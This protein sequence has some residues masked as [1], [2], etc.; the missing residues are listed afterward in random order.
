VSEIVRVQ[1]RAVQVGDRV[2]FDGGFEYLVVHRDGDAVTIERPD[3]PLS[4]KTGRPDPRSWADILAPTHAEAV[5]TVKDVLGASTLA[6]EVEGQVTRCPPLSQLVGD[7]ERLTEHLR[8][9]HDG[10]LLTKHVSL[11]DAGVMA[12]PHR[13]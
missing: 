13:H 11:H 8:A 7:A 12:I 2:R 1:W 3:E 10:D 4:S 9:F 5:A 6:D